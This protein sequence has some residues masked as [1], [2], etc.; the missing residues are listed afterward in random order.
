MLTPADRPSLLMITHFVPFP[1]DGG[2]AIRTYNLLRSFARGFDITLVCV[3]RTERGGDTSEYMRTQDALRQLCR[4]VVMVEHPPRSSLRSVCAFLAAEVRRVPYTN[5]EYPFAALARTVERLLET[6]QFEVIHLDS[7]DLAPLLG[8]VPQGRL[9]LNHHNVESELIRRR[10]T[11]YRVPMSWLVADQASLVEA[12]ER[13]ALPRVA[14]NVAVSERDAEILARL[15]GGMRMHV[16]PNAAD[17]DFYQPAAHTGDDVVFVGGT[18]WFPNRDAL[19]FF[20]AEILPRLSGRLPQHARIVWVGKVS[21]DIRTAPEYA[22]IH[23][24]GYVDDIR[25]HVANGR[26]VIAPLRVGGGTRLKIVEA[27]AQGKAIV[28]TSLGCEGLEA[29]HEENMLIADSAEEFASAIV[30]LYE[31]DALRCHLEVRAREI[32]ERRY[33]W[34]HVGQLATDRYLRL[35]EDT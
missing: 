15:G 9:V 27:W 24:T 6:R 7:I 4:E 31:D 3:R 33:S 16:A 29:L 26:C 17:T 20:A 10:A 14:L 13:A 12:S 32:A 21:E 1:P 18:G 23:F 28:S 35:I 34:R 22:G 19:H 8:S 25:P 2:A 5:F 30:R 11:T